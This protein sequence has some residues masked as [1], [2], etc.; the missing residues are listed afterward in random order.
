MLG[1]KA[2]HCCSQL[3]PHHD[4]VT[5]HI[6]DPHV[7]IADIDRLSAAEPR[8]KTASNEGVSFRCVVAIEFDTFLE[9][10]RFPLICVR[11]QCRADARDRCTKKKT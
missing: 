6:P 9:R 7:P 5:G 3:H 4:G 2:M 1:L 8:G 11:S 10:R